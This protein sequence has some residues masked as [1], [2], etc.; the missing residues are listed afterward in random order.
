M[1]TIAG[2]SARATEHASAI[3][4]SALPASST[5]VVSVMLLIR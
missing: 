5:T 3:K 4:C 2:C 1:T